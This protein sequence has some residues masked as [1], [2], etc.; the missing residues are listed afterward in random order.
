MLRMASFTSIEELR[1]IG[2]GTLSVVC[3]MLSEILA[4]LLSEAERAEE[5][6]NIR[7]RERCCIEVMRSYTCLQTEKF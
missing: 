2:D 6:L 7:A 3:N 4:W 5:Q 1:R